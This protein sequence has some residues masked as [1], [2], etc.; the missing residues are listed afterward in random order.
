MAAS[1]QPKGTAGFTLPELLGV[2]AVVGI[3][4]A[5]LAPAF[6]RMRK[7]G[8]A[9]QCIAN[10]RQ[11]SV[12]CTTYALDH[13]GF[14]PPCSAQNLKRNSTDTY[15]VNLWYQYLQHAD[16]TRLDRNGVLP[17]ENYVDNDP[18][19]LTVYNCPAN[20]YRTSEWKTP[21]YAYN[22]YI[23]GKINPTENPPLSLRVRLGNLEQAARTILFVDAGVR[24]VGTPTSGAKGPSTILYYYTAFG[25]DF[26]WENSVNFDLHGGRANIVMADGHAESLRAADVKQRATEKPPTLLWSRENKS[27]EAYYW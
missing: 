2:F 13:D 7:S 27:G 4:L 26:R 15:A 3:L 21:S 11:L 20:P 16:V 12:A 10:L 1:H 19:K 17:N 14:L 8:Q 23:G 22:L 9:A 6:S 18:K 25:G 5:L 24:Q